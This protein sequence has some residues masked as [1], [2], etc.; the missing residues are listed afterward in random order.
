MRTQALVGTFFASGAPP[1]H[2]YTVEQVRAQSASI[3]QV[4]GP[5]PAV[6]SVRE[7]VVAADGRDIAARLYEPAEAPGATVV[8]LHG[9]GW[10]VG[11]LDTHDAMARTL[12][13]ESRC[14]AVSV[15]Y[16]LAPEAPFLAAVDDAFAAL[17]SA[18]DAFT[19]DNAVRD[20]A[21]AIRRG[22]KKES[23]LA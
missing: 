9:C 4:L 10:V 16:R 8:Y 15:D 20:V 3:Q 17:E 1:M 22:L 11:S 7:N 19:Q 2:Q 13:R 12:M 6:W 23:F 14:Q 5:G 21:A 18:A